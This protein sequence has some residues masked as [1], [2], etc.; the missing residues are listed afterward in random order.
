MARTYIKISSFLPFSILFLQ[1][2]LVISIALGIIGVTGF[3]WQSSQ[4]TFKQINTDIEDLSCV[5]KIKCTFERQANNVSS[6]ERINAL[7][8][9]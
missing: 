2:Y 3:L 5:L 1:K 9:N 6:K 8:Y 7:Y 4:L